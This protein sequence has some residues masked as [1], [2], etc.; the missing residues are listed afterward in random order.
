MG[1]KIS[2]KII[3]LGFVVSCCTYLKNKSPGYW[4]YMIC[5]FVHGC[6]LMF[7]ANRPHATPL[8]TPTHV[9]MVSK[10]RWTNP[11][12]S[13]GI[14]WAVSY[15]NYVKILSVR[16]DIDLTKWWTPFNWN[17]E[18]VC[19]FGIFVV[20]CCRICQIKI[21]KTKHRTKRGVEWGWAA[22]TGTSC[23]L[24]GCCWSITLFWSRCNSTIVTMTKRKT[25]K[26]KIQF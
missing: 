26:S 18:F 2:S 19:L 24:L 20:F 11:L 5:R 3:R 16:K 13:T 25:N 4:I 6:E 7:F 1:E 14:V 22:T 9:K 8:S 23:E 17:H 15:I 21:T 12:L 10:F